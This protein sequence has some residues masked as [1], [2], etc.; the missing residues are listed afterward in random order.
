L[1]NPFLINV[2][3]LEASPC[4]EQEDEFCLFNNF[5]LNK[6]TSTLLNPKEVIVSLTSRKQDY[7]VQD[8]IESPKST[9]PTQ[10]DLDF[11]QLTDAF[12]KNK[13]N[14]SQQVHEEKD[15]LLATPHI[16]DIDHTIPDIKDQSITDCTSIL[17]L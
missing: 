6:H 11:N 12:Q 17:P 4:F 8:K 9:L 10:I 2:D 3:D 16:I 14:I 15:P 13:D 1:N 7:Y 5:D